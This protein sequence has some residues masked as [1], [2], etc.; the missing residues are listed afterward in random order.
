MLLQTSNSLVAVV[1]FWGQICFRVTPACTQLYMACAWLYVWTD[2]LKIFSDRRLTVSVPWAY[3]EC[4][5]IVPW[6]YLCVQWAYRHCTVSL[7]WFYREL[8]VSV[9]WAYRECTVSVPWVY[10]ECT[11]SVPWLYHERTVWKK[12]FS[13]FFLL[14]KASVT[15]FVDRNKQSR[16]QTSPLFVNSRVL[17]HERQCLFFQ[18]TDL[19]NK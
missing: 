8:T 7:P 14:T 2:A 4:T 11:V 17:L 3:R 9:P 13:F 18:D 16:W 1:L 12:K 5:V 19:L 6:A 15:A 10:R